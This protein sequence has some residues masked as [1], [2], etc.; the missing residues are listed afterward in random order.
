MVYL[1]ALTTAM[2]PIFSQ[3]VNKIYTLECLQAFRLV[4]LTTYLTDIP[5][6]AKVLKIPVYG[7]RCTMRTVAL[8]SRCLLIHLQL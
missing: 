3:E 7:W 8:L 2:H 6:W 5:P 1:N 4:L